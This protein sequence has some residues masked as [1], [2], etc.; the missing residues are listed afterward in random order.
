MLEKVEVADLVGRVEI[1]DLEE[2]PITKTK[3]HVHVKE[4]EFGENQAL[5][6]LN[7]EE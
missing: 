3:C 6:T 4:E 1:E 7:P 5:L 2:K